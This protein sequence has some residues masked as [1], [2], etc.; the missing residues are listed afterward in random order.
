MHSFCVE[1][2]KVYT[3]TGM[4]IDHENLLCKEM[5]NQSSPTMSWCN[6]GAVGGAEK[7]TL[8]RRPLGGHTVELGAPLLGVYSYGARGGSMLCDYNKQDPTS[9]FLFDR[10]EYIQV[11]EVFFTST[12]TQARTHF[13]C[14]CV[15][16]SHAHAHT[17][18]ALADILVVCDGLSFLLH[19]ST[20]NLICGCAPDT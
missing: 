16:V 7:L 6:F 10:M 17:N 4:P 15:C 8:S 12:R 20:R 11:A 19:F 9:C 2:P 18:I 13:L 1:I 14:A 5:R 3:V